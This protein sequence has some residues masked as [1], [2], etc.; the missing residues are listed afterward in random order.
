MESVL[1]NIYAA[2]C[3]RGWTRRLK[4]HNKKSVRTT[5]SVHS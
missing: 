4:R 5:T 2:R 1:V 3:V